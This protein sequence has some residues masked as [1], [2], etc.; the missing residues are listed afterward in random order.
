MLRNSGKPELRVQSI[1][2]AIKR[3]FS[4]DARVKPGHD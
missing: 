4:M 2:F 3:F 1:H